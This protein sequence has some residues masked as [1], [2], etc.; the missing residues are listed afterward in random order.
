MPTYMLLCSSLC[1]EVFTTLLYSMRFLAF[2][3]LSSPFRTAGD[4]QGPSRCCCFLICIDCIRRRARNEHQSGNADR[5]FLYV[6]LGR[7]G[8]RA[9]PK[10][11]LWR[12]QRAEP[13]RS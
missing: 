13:L 8:K 11:I 10:P 7:E 5:L 1:L 9:L 3:L 6:V 12:A 4:R 2:A